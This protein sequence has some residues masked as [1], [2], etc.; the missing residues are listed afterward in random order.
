MNIEYWGKKQ[1]YCHFEIW[2][3]EYC[4]PCFSAMLMAA[5]GRHAALYKI[6]IQCLADTELS[7]NV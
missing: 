7:S 1:E 5:M 2:I 4:N 6:L 3:L